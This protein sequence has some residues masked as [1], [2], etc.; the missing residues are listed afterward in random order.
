[1]IDFKY[2]EKNRARIEEALKR[3]NYKF[4]I[5]ALLNDG[6]ERKKL[7]AEVEAIRARMNE[8]SGKIGKLINSGSEAEI[9]ELKNHATEV[10]KNLDEKGSALKAVQ[11]KLNLSLLLLPNML[12]ESVPEG[13]ARKITRW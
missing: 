4:D 9:T 3:R 5:S 13:R 12:H 8:V 10:K 1:M 7:S 2:F 11:E 6:E